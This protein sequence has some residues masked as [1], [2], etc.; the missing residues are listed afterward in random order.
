MTL[1]NR[2]SIPPQDETA[3]T[4]TDFSTAM[5]E[6]AKETFGYTKT[7][8][9]EWISPDIWRTIEKRRQLEKMALDSKSSRLKNGA[10]VQYREKDKQV[11]TSAIRD[12]RRYVERLAIEAEAAAWR[13]DVKTVYL[14]TRKLHGDRGKNHDLTV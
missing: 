9:F 11:R 2:F 1:R 8:K 3:L 10:V 14:I 13:K 5:M 6:S 4:F 7:C 12:K